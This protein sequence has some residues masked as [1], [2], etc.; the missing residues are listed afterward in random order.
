MKE[1]FIIFTEELVIIIVLEMLMKHVQL[2][3]TLV[4]L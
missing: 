1:K 4:R 2:E 3:S